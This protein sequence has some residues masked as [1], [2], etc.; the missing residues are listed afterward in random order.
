MSEDLES[1]NVK[2]AGQV[3]ESAVERL[4]RVQRMYED[5]R[6]KLA[7]W[8]SHQPDHLK[9]ERHGTVRELDWEESV[10]RTWNQREFVLVYKPCRDCIKHAEESQVRQW[11]LSRGVPECICHASFDNFIATTDSQRSALHAAR[12]LVEK[13]R[14]FLLMFG[15]PGTGKTHLAVATLRAA[16]VGRFMVV[17]DLASKVREWMDRQTDTNIETVCRNARLLV[18]DDVHSACTTGDVRLARDIIAARHARR[19]PTVITGSVEIRLFMESL[20][21]TLADRISEACVGQIKFKGASERAATG[22]KAY[23]HE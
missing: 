8:A 22:K 2:S 7:E 20:G 9:C 1:G 23:W 11:L 5:V 15:E 21:P 3:V 13:M 4:Q 17:S 6:R 16:R 14:G 12:C 19:A 10:R 18:L